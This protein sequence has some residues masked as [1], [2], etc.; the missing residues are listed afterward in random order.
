MIYHIIF[1][2]FRLLTSRFPAHQT[3]FSSGQ[4]SSVCRPSACSQPPTRACPSGRP[5]RSGSPAPSLRWEGQLPTFRWRQG[6]ARCWPWPTN[7]VFSLMPWLS[8]PASPY[9]YVQ[10]GL[11]GLRHTG[12]RN[13]RKASYLFSLVLF[14]PGIRPFPI[15]V[16]LYI[17]LCPGSSC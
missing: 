9:K 6:S 3:C 11:C 13:S 15:S 17:F 7:T 8:S 16:T 2:I 4:P 5:T 14:D 12:K 10:S 1:L